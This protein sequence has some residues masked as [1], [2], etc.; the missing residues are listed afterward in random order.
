M[1]AV[2]KETL[3]WLGALFSLCGGVVWVRTATVKATYR[4]VQHEKEISQVQ[5]EL[6]D[7]RI[8]WLKLTSPKRLEALAEKYRMLPTQPGQRVQISSK[9]T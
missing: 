8:R 6:Q 1:L 3:A 9:K 2:K 4:Y 7:A 5:Q